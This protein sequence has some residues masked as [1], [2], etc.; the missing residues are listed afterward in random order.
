MTEV[1]HFPQVSGDNLNRVAYQLPQSFEAELNLV[2]L[3]FYQEQQRD[4]NTWLAFADKLENQR[5][6]LRY[7]EL[8]IL[9]QANSW[10]R[11]FIDGGM[12][13]GIRDEATRA[14][15]IT[16]YLDRQ[17]FLNSMGLSSDQTIYTLL[18]KRSG[19]VLWTCD[20]VYSEAK[21]QSLTSRVFA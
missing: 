9:S 18:V 21:S 7:Y 13:S 6:D 12:R 4:V 2:F 19:E 5:D 1:I 3:A 20:G 10:F 14:R 15:T 8:P 11:A 17:A 16:L